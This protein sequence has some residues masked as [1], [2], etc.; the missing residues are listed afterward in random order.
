M[1]MVV[2]NEQ[3]SV[4]VLGSLASHYGMDKGA[5][6]QTVKATVMSGANVSNEQLAA[7]CLVAKEHKLNPFTKEIFAFPSRGGIVPVVSVDGWMKLIN[8]H[9]QFDGMEF[10]DVLNEQGG[11]LAVT[12]RI[13]RKDRSHP[14]EVT[15]Y[16]SECRRNTD[17]WKQWPARMLRH[18]ATIQ[19]ARYAFGFA[20][21]LE[22]DEA[23]R[24]GDATSNQAEIVP[25]IAITD[26][27]KK[28]C[29]EAAEQYRPS[30]D[31]IKAKISEWDQDDNSDHLY[32][33][34]EAWYG[35]PQAAQ[36][37]LYLAPS[38]G[39]VFTTHERDVIKTK[40]PKQSIEDAA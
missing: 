3:A 12:C 2:S 1:N 30:V 4:G 11:L 37:D 28:R 6:I 24:M 35:L 21:I 32:T 10:K 18:K 14:V 25:A 27:R 20:G 22:Q 8:S 23:E 34:A 39:G 19:A 9:P 5:F 15:E 33:V 26:D 7:F 31:L 17:V 13:F 40:L 38:K 36:M 29:D 16:M